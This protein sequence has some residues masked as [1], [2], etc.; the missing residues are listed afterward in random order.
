MTL[1]D[2]ELQALKRTHEFMRSILT[3]RVSDFR[4]MKKE[5]FERWRTDCYY[6]I[7]HYPFDCTIDRL[8]EERIQEMHDS[9]GQ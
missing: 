8:W 2:Q 7:K 6:C 4:K 9:F 1:P 5:E 3:M